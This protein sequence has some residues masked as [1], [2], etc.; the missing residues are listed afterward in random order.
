MSFVMFGKEMGLEDLT[1]FSR[2]SCI[3][4]NVVSRTFFLS[5]IGS[6][7]ARHQLSRARSELMERCQAGES[8]NY[9]AI[10]AKGIYQWKYKDILS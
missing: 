10:N 9:F 2:I 1:H 8:E 7:N 5:D 3:L 6:T 4:W